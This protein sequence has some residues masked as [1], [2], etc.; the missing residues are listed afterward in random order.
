MSPHAFAQTAQTAQPA[1]AEAPLAADAEPEAKEGDIV[2]TGSRIRNSTYTST[3]PITTIDAE[4]AAQSG[5]IGAA[6]ILQTAPVAASKGQVNN[7]YTGYV[8]GGGAGI[9]TISLR[10]LGDQRSLVLLNGRRMPPSG[11]G[12]SVGPVDLSTIPSGLVARY[13]IL[14]DG[15]SSVYGSDAVAGVVNV[16]T[17]SKAEGLDV[18][19]TAVGTQR[20]GA[21]TYDF[22]GSWGRAFDNGH[23]SV[24]AEYYNQR[25]LTAGQR[26]D[27]ACPTH[28]Y[29]KPD[30]SRAD[31]IDPATGQIKCYL[32]T[33]AEGA[34]F[35][36]YPL[37]ATGTPLLF[38]VYGAK[39][40]TVSQNVL[41]FA[42][43]SGIAA[44]SYADPRQLS[45][46]VFSPLKRI[47]A[48]VQGE[49]R[50]SWL[51]TEL[52]TELLYASR[53]SE[54]V[55]WATLSPFY[56]RKSTANP[57][58]NA[59]VPGLE[60]NGEVGLIARPQVLYEMASEQKVDVFRG[61]AGA[62][63]SIKGWGYDVYVSH[64]AS[65]GKYSS[66]A[67]YNDRIAFGTGTDQNTLL[68][69]P[70]GVC[71]AGAPAGCV[72]L[73]L[74]S[75]KVLEDGEFSQ[76]VQDYFFTRDAGTTD[77]NQSIFEASV[78]GDLFDLPYGALSSAFGVALRHESI[79][80][81]PGTLSSTHNIWGRT[82][83]GET[84]GDETVSEI[85]GEI[86]GPLLRN[87]PFV[88]DLKF[89]ISGRYSNYASVGGAGTYKVG[90]NWAINDVVRLRATHGTSFRAPSLY[91]LNLKDQRGFLAQGNVDPCIGFDQTGADGA[92]LETNQR[93]RANCAASGLPAGFVGGLNNVTVR[94]SGGGEDLKAE[95]S[96]ATTVG[97][98]L[99][100]PRTGLKLAVD[101]W[102]IAIK[103]QISNI[104][105]AAPSACYNADDFPTSGYCGL[106]VRDPVDF[107]IDSI[108]TRYTNVPSET[109]SGIDFTGSYEHEFNLGTFSAEL[110]GSY[111]I[112]HKTQP[113]AGDAE[114][115]YVG[116]LGYPE[117]VGNFSARFQIKKWLAAWTV[118]YTG[119]TSN[120]G[121]YGE[122]G[123]LTGGYAS[124]A[125]YVASTDAF[126][127]Q[128]LFFAFNART[129]QLLAGVMN[130]TNEKAP[131]VG[132]GISFQ[133]TGN[134]VWSSQYTAGYMGRQLFLRLRK[135]F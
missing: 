57:F 18:S 91:E 1:P 15:A 71:G 64:S 69:L 39:A 26:A 132:D 99:T 109:S 85:Y 3:S 40:G 98:A 119:P 102:R 73:D 23:I 127:T 54:Q 88:E 37:E 101:Y 9:N 129:W 17:R 34:V 30:G 108:D 32:S 41:G 121:R 49:Y 96:Q 128:D 117:L 11:V 8:V 62:R 82:T 130:V 93:I 116:M 118:N 28:N 92:F 113:F 22:N 29:Y 59:I 12:G 84:R 107:G 42:P 134:Y 21:F 111:I 60:A 46:T 35:T 79:D 133:R 24:G 123:T 104:G 50:P 51:D 44:L 13:E 16:I 87:L 76:A 2:V 53:Q 86:E 80:D 106:F 48:F 7:T 114:Q 103:D 74:F 36:Y 89:N 81:Q 4:K 70:G 63:G 120:I 68:S 110:A 75:K 19:A 61:L 126:I 66:D 77:Y 10:G 100:P 31:L 67:V 105:T 5:K 112:E 90:L 124:G 47:S 72:P 83:A 52:Y 65:R 14:K 55:G 43:V 27:F 33:Q 56:A 115:E 25:A 20:G 131:V 58:R 95:T 6:E 135:L 38:N 45:E 94:M 97:I 125:T 78:T 122:T